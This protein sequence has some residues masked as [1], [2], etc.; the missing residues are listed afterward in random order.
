MERDV[1]HVHLLLCHLVLQDGLLTLQKL[2][3]VII[4]FYNILMPSFLS[5]IRLLDKSLAYCVGWALTSQYRST[6]SYRARILDGDFI[7]HRLLL[8]ESVRIF[9][10]SN[11]KI[12]T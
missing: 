5:W 7:E 12:S 10:A 1:L 4:N 9:S 8:H 6:E 2:I 3:K 11:K